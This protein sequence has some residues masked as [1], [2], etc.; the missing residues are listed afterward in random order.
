LALIPLYD[1]ERKTI[2]KKMYLMR[3]PRGPFMLP[4]TGVKWAADDS[5]SW[6]QDY[7][8]QIK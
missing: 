3:D 8:Q 5:V 2:E 1:T 4:Y 7:R 6:T